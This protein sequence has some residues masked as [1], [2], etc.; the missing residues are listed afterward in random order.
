MR[1]I[2]RCGRVPPTGF[3]QP[4]SGRLVPLGQIF[5]SIHSGEQKAS[6]TVMRS[7]GGWRG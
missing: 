4:V 1:S 3:V 7:P 6:P 2:L 5:A